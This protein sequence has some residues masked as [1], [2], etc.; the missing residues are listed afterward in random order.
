MNVKNIMAGSQQDIEDEVT[1]AGGTISASLLSNMTIAR[2]RALV[3]RGQTLTDQIQAATDLVNTD[4]TLV[5]D[6]KQMAQEQFTNNMS[7]LKYQQDNYQNQQN[8]AKDTIKMLLGPNMENAQAV[9]NSVKGT[10]YESRYEQVLGLPAGGMA[11]LAAI[12]NTQ[13][14]KDQLQ[15]QG[16]K[17]DNAK[18]SAD[19]S[20]STPGTKAYNTAQDKLEQQYRTVLLKEASN[21]SGDLGIQNSKVSQA[22]HLTALLDQYKDPKTGNYNV[23]TAQYAELAM[24]LANL[25]SPSGSAESDRQAIL[26]K[27]ASGD[28]KGALSYIIGTPQNGNTQQIIKNLAD[29]I[30]RQ[31]ATAEDLRDEQVNFLQGLAPTGLDQS[32]IEAL[33]KNTLPSYKSYKTNGSLTGEKETPKLLAPAEIPSGYYQ[34]SD[35]LLYEK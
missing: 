19:L 5:G 25:I 31:G 7:L 3:Q 16:L 10:P 35:G 27:T 24:G 13:A 33:N 30:D 1:K 23:P 20:A 18:K 8:A 9:Y 11:Q 4:T 21:R 29:S 12:P 2:N 28:I 6:M 15:I 26:S 34:A 32:R 22:V 14:I 17:L